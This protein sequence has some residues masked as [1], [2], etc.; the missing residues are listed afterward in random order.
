[1]KVNTLKIGIDVDLT[2]VDSGTPWIEWLEKVYGV[3]MDLSL[4]P[5][6]PQGMLYYNVS[7]YFPPAKVHQLSPYE[8]WEDPY[9]YDKLKPLPGAVE[10][11]AAWAKAGHFNHFVSYCMKGHFSS[12]VRFL[13]RETEEFFSLEPGSG[14]AFYATKHKAGVDV[15]VIIDDRNEFLNQ[16]GPE[17]IKIKFKTP[18]D[19]SEELKTSIDLETDDWYTIRDF[20]L[21]IA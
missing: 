9:L 15:D 21:D 11:V 2:F 12:K 19:Q 17:V 20:V 6:N 13:K 18:Y 3:K 16:F 8:F 5:P 14:H 4:P 1:M 7:K 10:A